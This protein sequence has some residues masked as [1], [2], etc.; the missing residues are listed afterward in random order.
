MLTLCIGS[1][2]V[3]YGVL[4]SFDVFTLQ[5][6]SEKCIIFFPCWNLTFTRLETERPGGVARD[7]ALPMVHF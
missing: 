6:A 7:R 3:F 4:V 2:G 5:L 1:L